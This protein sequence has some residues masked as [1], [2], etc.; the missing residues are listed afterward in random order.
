[1]P[2]PPSFPLILEKVA[3]CESGNGI[4]GSARQFNKDG[5]VLRGRVVPDDIG[6]MQINAYWHLEAAIRL[7]YDIYTL[8]G[9]RAYGLYLYN[10]QGLQP[11]S[12]SKYCWSNK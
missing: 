6:Y 10:T 3:A 9:N 5:S 2:P 7:G 4:V 8:E 12:A 1:M 11:W